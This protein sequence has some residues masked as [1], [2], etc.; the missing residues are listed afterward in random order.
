MKLSFVFLMVF[1]CN[2][3]CPET[4]FL[5]VDKTINGVKTDKPVHIKDGMLDGFFDLGHIVFDSGPKNNG[6][7]LPDLL[8]IAFNGGAQYLV[9]TNVLSTVLEIDADTQRI[10]FSAFYRIF[11]ASTGLP[12]AE[13]ETETDN[14]GQEKEVNPYDIEFLFGV[15]VSHLVATSLSILNRR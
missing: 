1:I 2:T 6:E 15:D 5:H 7:T 11:D 14:K 12:L 8:R 3:V 9:F 4:F 10:E 13:G